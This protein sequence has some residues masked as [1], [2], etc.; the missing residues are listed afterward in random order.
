MHVKRNQVFKKIQN[1]SSEIKLII[2]SLQ[3]LGIPIFI[4]SDIRNRKICTVKKVIIYT[5]SAYYLLM[6]FC[7]P[8]S[9]LT[10]FNQNN[11][12]TVY[13]INRVLSS[14]SIFLLRVALIIKIKK[15]KTV[16]CSLNALKSHSEG[17]SVSIFRSYIS[18]F[19]CVGLIMPIVIHIYSLFK[20]ETKFPFLLS[21]K[22]GI[23]F[24]ISKIIVP[25]LDVTFSVTSYLFP[26][27]TTI[28]FSFIYIYFA[29][30]LQQSF[31][32][33]LY[34]GL[35]FPTTHN[36]KVCIDMYAKLRQMWLE[37]EEYA[38]FIVLIIYSLSISQLLHVIKV[39]NIL[40]KDIV[41]VILR[42][43]LS[44]TWLIILSVS[45][46]ESSNAWEKNRILVQG[47]I[48]SHGAT[49]N[50]VSNKTLLYL[51]GLLDATRVDMSFTCFGICPN[52]VSLLIRVAGLIITF[53]ALM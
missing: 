7:F 44:L 27:I 46:S 12:N 21:Y 3:F 14:I 9:Q 32:T 31:S 20:K 18:Y 13:I 42:A 1:V 49:Y 37:I 48:R 36:I 43:I 8:L 39:E 19:Y 4:E 53:W 47:I 45:G 26:T 22:Y 50:E 34:N 11:F 30:T 29:R 52:E 16:L 35:Q 5:L 51:T 17:H 38:S 6:A 41:K 25:V 23:F 24:S 10:N 28:L 15:L 33:Q 40:H 2:F